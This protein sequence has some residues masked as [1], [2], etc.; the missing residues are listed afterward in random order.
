MKRRSS[1]EIVPTLPCIKV[2]MS[3]TRLWNRKSTDALSRQ[4][5]SSRSYLP[6]QHNTENL[7]IMEW[8]DN[9][10]SLI[11]SAASQCSRRAGKTIGTLDSTVKRNTEVIDDFKKQL[12]V[13]KMPPIK[14]QKSDVRKAKPASNIISILKPPPNRRRSDSAKSQR[15]WKN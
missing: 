15:R 14:K 2:T 3:K 7:R 8:S 1:Q 9:S 13:I 4:Y 5:E 11:S 10:S 12:E 6:K